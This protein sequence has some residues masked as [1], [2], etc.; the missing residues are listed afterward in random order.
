MF[1]FPLA[2]AS[3]HVFEEFAWPGG[4]T[5]WYH[6]YRP[7]IARSVS[8]KFLFWINAALLF[9]A[10]SV[11]MDERTPIGPAF[12]LTFCALLAGNGMF[13]LYA[14][15]TTRH[16]SP[17][18]V[19]G[20]L[21]YIPLALYGFA[22]LIASGRASISTALVAALIGGSYHFVSVAN[23]RRRSVAAQRTSA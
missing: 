1:W 20:A 16:Y 14:T 21:L 8:K 23:H 2:A 15:L 4:F 12:F 10:F 11:G 7:E 5:A 6:R 19:T 18:V 22:T 3:A 13:H 9:G 17:G